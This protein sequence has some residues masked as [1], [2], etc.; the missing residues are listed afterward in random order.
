MQL[1]FVIDMRVWYCD[2]RG[3][4]FIYYTVSLNEQHTKGP[5]NFSNSNSN[6]T[7]AMLSHF[8]IICVAKNSWWFRICCSDVEGESSDVWC[9]CLLIPDYIIN[10]PTQI[11]CWIMTPQTKFP[12]VMQQGEICFRGCAIV[13]S[14]FDVTLKYSPLLCFLLFTSC[15]VREFEFCCVGI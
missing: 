10:D 12:F 11:W 4:P 9:C 5:F 2:A 14:I 3:P 6:K 1:V 7:S 13:H 8:A 15:L